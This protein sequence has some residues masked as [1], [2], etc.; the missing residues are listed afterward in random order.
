[1]QRQKQ[2][3][4][5]SIEAKKARLQ[6]LVI[7]KVMVKNLVD[8]NA[9]LEEQ[10]TPPDPSNSP[11]VGNTKALAFRVIA[12]RVNMPFILIKTHQDTVIDCEMSEDK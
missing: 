9:Q 6:E 7:Q 1:M 4:L 5:D 8:H 12:K 11:A 2:E 10:A 3:R